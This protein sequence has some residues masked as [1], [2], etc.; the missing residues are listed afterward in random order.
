M[1]LQLFCGDDTLSVSGLPPGLADTS[2]VLDVSE[3]TQSFNYDKS[4]S[5]SQLIK[6][7]SRNLQKLLKYFHGKT[8]S[9]SNVLLPASVLPVILVLYSVTILTCCC[10]FVILHKKRSFPLRISWVNV[11]KSAVPCGFGHI[12]W[13]NPSWK[14]HFL[15]YVIYPIITSL[16]IF[17]CIIDYFISIIIR[18]TFWYHRIIF[19]IF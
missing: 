14:P 6:S 2:G 8:T 15:C 19:T 12:Y 5:I 4:S 7:K 3:I 17:I 18:Q 11:T 1:F 10:L 9:V 16:I 13:R